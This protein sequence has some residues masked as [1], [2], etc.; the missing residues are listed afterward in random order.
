MRIAFVLLLTNV[1]V[2]QQDPRGRIEGRVTDTSGAVV[3]NA[4]VKASN[5][6]TGVASNGVTNQQGLYEIPF[7]NPGEYSL[8]VEI[9]GFKKL[10][11]ASA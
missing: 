4:S 1:L 7:L 3:P 6:A 10:D 11:P 9:S 2:A 5:L 8:Q